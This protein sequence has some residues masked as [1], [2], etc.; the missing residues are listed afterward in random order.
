MREHTGARIA[1]L[2]RALDELRRVADHAGDLPAAFLEPEVAEA[3][4]VLRTGFVPEETFERHL[5][6]EVGG[7]GLRDFV[8]LGHAEIQRRLDVLDG[9]LAAM[10]AGG[11][12][13]DPLGGRRLA[14]ELY[15]LEALLGAQLDAER[16]LLANT[17]AR[18]PATMQGTHCEWCG[19]EYP[20]PDEAG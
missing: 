2:E 7:D 12:A 9:E 3:V 16:W 11:V 8:V 17:P 6:G 14:R 20:V 10:R 1:E 4:G 5:A 15:G 18:A 19:A 13:A